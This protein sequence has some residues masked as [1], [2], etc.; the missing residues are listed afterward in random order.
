L[1]QFDK[2]LAAARDDEV[3]RA[4]GA[5]QQLGHGGAV[6]RRNRLNRVLGQ[7]CLGQARAHRGDD[8][9]GRAGAV[10][11]AAQD[12]GIARFQAQRAGIGCDI[13]PRFIDHADDADRYRHALDCQPV[14][15]LD[16]F[17]HAADRVG[18]SGDRFQARGHRLDAVG[19]KRQAVQKRGA[20]SARCCL[21][22][23]VG[24][25]GD[26][27]VGAVPKRARR[28]AERGV[29]G[30]SLSPPKC[31]QGGAGASAKLPDLRF[32]FG[33]P[34]AFAAPAAAGKPSATTRPTTT[35]FRSASLGVHGQGG[36]RRAP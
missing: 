19:G 4:V 1:D 5:A 9:R 34:P 28:C 23:I 31:R 10:A 26:E 14:R 8:D 6:G 33:H 18:Q 30:G 32:R 3:H 27:L 20:H 17:E 2:T 7:T 24:V 36:Y 22:A 16:P 15:A 21:Q 13:G 35:A 12:H 25:D 11:P 29:F